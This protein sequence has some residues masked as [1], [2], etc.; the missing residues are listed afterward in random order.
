MAFQSKG[1]KSAL[2]SELPAICRAPSDGR[3]GKSQ[4]KQ[5]LTASPVEA[6]GSIH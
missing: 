2:L 3:K 4:N 6:L 5:Q 1:E